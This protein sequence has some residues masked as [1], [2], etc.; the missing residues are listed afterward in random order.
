MSA[1]MGEGKLNVLQNSLVAFGHCHIDESKLSCIS[2]CFCG[3]GVN[4]PVNVEVTT[5]G[6]TLSPPRQLSVSVTSLLPHYKRNKNSD[7][8]M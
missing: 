7:I 1:V 4:N 6:L 2:G 5:K 3:L 8:L